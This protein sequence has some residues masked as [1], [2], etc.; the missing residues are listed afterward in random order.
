MTER[1]EPLRDT[2]ARLTIENNLMRHLIA[3][4]DMDC[5]YCHL[6]KAQMNRCASGFPGCGRADD[7]MVTD[8]R[9]PV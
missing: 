3:A 1:V 6:P 5:L 9:S 2:V 7:L 8:M 4:S